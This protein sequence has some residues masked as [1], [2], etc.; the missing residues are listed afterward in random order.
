[1]VPPGVQA[2]VPETRLVTLRYFQQ[3][4]FAPAVAGVPS[5]NVFRCNSLYD[6]DSTG[7][8]GQPQA[9]DQ[10][11]ALYNSYTVIGA[12]ITVVPLSNAAASA[13]GVLGI[14]TRLSATT[15][16]DLRTYIEGPLTVFS[17]VKT[18][19]EAQ[20]LVLGFSTK[21]HMSVVNPLDDE[22][23]KGTSGSNPSNVAYWHVFYSGPTSAVSGGTCNA[24]VLI[25]YTAILSD[26]KDLANS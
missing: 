26:A 20:P 10:Y 2:A 4:S 5:V 15:E 6:P 21:K 24:Q 8:G 9:F 19:A 25:E 7:G 1:M 23:L 14:Q 18:W 16:T 12:K 13:A 17:G 3:V 22:S 11:M